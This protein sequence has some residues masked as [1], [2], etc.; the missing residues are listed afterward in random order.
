MHLQ[1]KYEFYYRKNALLC[2]RL[3]FSFQW[4]NQRGWVVNIHNKSMKSEAVEMLN[5]LSATDC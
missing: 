3:S 4:K 5:E 2:G 1:I